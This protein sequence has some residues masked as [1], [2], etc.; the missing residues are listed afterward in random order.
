MAPSLRR[1]IRKH[2]KGDDASTNTDYSESDDDVGRNTGMH[3]MLY[4]SESN[5]TDS[6][7][8]D[9]SDFKSSEADSSKSGSMRRRQ[10]TGNMRDKK[11]EIPLELLEAGF[12]ELDNMLTNLAGDDFIMGTLLDRSCALIPYEMERQTIVPKVI[13]NSVERKSIQP[14]SAPL[15]VDNPVLEE[16]EQVKDEIPI[17][18]ASVTMSNLELPDIEGMSIKLKN[19]KKAIEDRK[20]FEQTQESMQMKLSMYS[21]RISEYALKLEQMQ[22]ERDDNVSLVS[23]DVNNL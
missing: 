18:P 2:H 13:L 6:V 1:K 9:D 10:D 14:F 3:Q 16:M 21:E 17:T 5:D 7:R 20:Q 19:L 8:S 11:K 22:R 15:D 4:S 23:R 12:N